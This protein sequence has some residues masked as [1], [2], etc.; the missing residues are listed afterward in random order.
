MRAF[1]G[2]FLGLVLVSL[3][4]CCLPSFNVGNNETAKAPPPNDVTKDILNATVMVHHADPLGQEEPKLRCTGVLY[5][6]Y[7]LTAAH[8]VRH[9]TD[10]QTNVPIRLYYDYIHSNKTYI[11]TV[12]GYYNEK[13]D[14]AI[15]FPTGVLKS[16]HKSVKLAPKVPKI[17]GKVVLIGHPAGISYTITVG[18]VSTPERIIHG[19]KH[20]HASVLMTAG[21]SGGPLFNKYG[22]LIGI[23]SFLSLSSRGSEDHI[24][25]FIH[26]DTIKEV[27]ENDSNH[28]SS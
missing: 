21:N 24:S 6:N 23:A 14:F 11:P 25:M 9:A 17:G 28:S 12:V 22:E 18:I 10:K 13:T 7:V 20:L 4:V 1:F 16:P 15:L 3:N 2:L 19:V 5:W 26:L 27:L 8:C